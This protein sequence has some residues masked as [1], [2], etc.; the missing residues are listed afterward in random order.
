MAFTNHFYHSLTRKYVAIFGSLFDKLSIK[1]Y[2][3]DL[4]KTVLQTI[5]VPISYGPWAKFLARVESDPILNRKYQM[6][7]PRMTFE[8]EGISYDPERRSSLLNK[9][10]INKD[11]KTF[12]YNPAPYKLNFTLSIIASHV[13]D[14]TQIIEQILPFF[15]P[16]Y[17][18]SVF[19]IEGLEEPID[20]SID[21]DNVSSEDVYED[22]YKGLRFVKWTLTFT[23]KGYYFGP[24]KTKKIIKFVDVK[25]KTQEKNDEFLSS[26]ITAQPGLDVN[27]NPTTNIDETI[28]YQSINIDDAWAEL[29]QIHSIDEIIEK[30]LTSSDPNMNETNGKL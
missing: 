15:Q 26:I 25:I 12:V 19:L 13:E 4:Q 8:L 6:A 27:G 2:D 24:A 29:I 1:R 20:I 9:I 14:G 17:T 21:L 23:M 30:G 18:P 7:L 5:P 11:D 22:D 16:S 28:N 10:I 3:N